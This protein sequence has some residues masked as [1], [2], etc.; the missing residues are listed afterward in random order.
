MAYP[1]SSSLSTL[2]QP[3]IWISTHRTQVFGLSVPFLIIHLIQTKQMDI[4][5]PGTGIW[6]IHSVFHYPGYSNLT[7]GYP[8][9]GHRYLA[10]PYCSS[11]STLFKPN[12]WISTHWAQVFGLFIQFLIIRLI[13][14]KQMEIHTPGAGIWLIHSVPHYPPYP[15]PTYGY[16][17]TG[18]RYLAYSFSSSSSTLSKPNK[19]RSTHWRHFLKLFQN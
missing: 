11:L 3:N 14:T 5:T 13:Q 1:F 17:H 7:Y 8:H 12:I 6:L 2:S 18:H 19:W 15:N 9:T 16:P 10:Y 4:H